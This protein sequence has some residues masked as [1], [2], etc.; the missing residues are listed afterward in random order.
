MST[1]EAIKVFVEKC[2]DLR[3]VSGFEYTSMYVFN[4][5][6]KGR[7]LAH[8]KNPTFNTLYSV[9]KTTGEIGVFNPRNMPL[10]EY[11]AGKKLF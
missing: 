1:Q 10:D 4:A 8:R 2:P 9:N 5:A 3:L 6:P 7:E 11:R